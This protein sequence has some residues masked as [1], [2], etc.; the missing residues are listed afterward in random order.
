MK[1]GNKII[2]VGAL[3]LGL[4][5]CSPSSGSALP[6]GYVS[7]SQEELGNLRESRDKAVEM[8]SDMRKIRDGISLES[9]LNY[10]IFSDMGVNIETYSGD[11]HFLDG[12]RLEGQALNYHVISQKHPSRFSEIFR[13]Y[14]IPDINTVSDDEADDLRNDNY[15]LSKELVRNGKLKPQK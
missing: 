3:V 2:G 6:E 1:K 7:I 10:S 14:G 13:K 4:A 8:K 9:H 15:N 5:G 12:N 11:L